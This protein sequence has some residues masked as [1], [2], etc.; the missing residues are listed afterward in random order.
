MRFLNA[1][2]GVRKLRIALLLSFLTAA[3]ALLPLL[4]MLLSGRAKTFRF[5]IILLGLVAFIFSIVILVLELM[6]VSRAKRDERSFRTARTLIIF[7]LVIGFF[8]GLSDR[9]AGENSPL[10]FLLNLASDVLNIFFIYY[11]IQGISNLAVRLKDLEFPVTG[12]RMLRFY[13]IVGCGSILI[14]ILSEIISNSEA[15]AVVLIVLRIV[16]AV[17][18]LVVDILFYRYLTRAERMLRTKCFDPEPG[19]YWTEAGQWDRV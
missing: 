11:I 4:L 15:G 13:I 5:V 18:S 17:L 16:A 14:S 8:L 3:F 1:A 10:S 12:S 7:S 9:L 19:V 6:G 2:E